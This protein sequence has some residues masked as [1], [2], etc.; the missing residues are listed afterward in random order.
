MSRLAGCDGGADGLAFGVGAAVLALS[1][2]EGTED[3][4][5][6]RFEGQRG[7]LSE[8]DDVVAVEICGAATCYLTERTELAHPG[9]YPPPSRAVAY[10]TPGAC[11]GALVSVLWAPTRLGQLAALNARARQATHRA[12]VFVE[13]SD[14]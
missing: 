1:V 11:P 8:A 13:D 6:Q 14:L 10:V 2:M 3:A 12:S 5:V 4:E 7:I 9:A